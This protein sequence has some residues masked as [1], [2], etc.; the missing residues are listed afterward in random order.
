VTD[1]DIN[2]VSWLAPF[3]RFG[4]QV[5]KDIVDIANNRQCSD[6]FKKYGLTIPYDQVLSDNLR[7]VPLGFLYDD[8]AARTLGVRQE[9]VDSIRNDLST[10]NISWG[11]AAATIRGTV[12]SIIVIGPA[13]NLADYGGIRS[14]LIHELIHAGERSGSGDGLTETLPASTATKR[15]KQLVAARVIDIPKY[16]YGCNSR[17]NQTWVRQRAP[18]DSLHAR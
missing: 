1:R 10:G 9:V 18:M 17:K 5:V 11:D 13:A 16:L 12:S 7:I 14:V 8:A 2:I 3:D 15:F 4:A 6:A